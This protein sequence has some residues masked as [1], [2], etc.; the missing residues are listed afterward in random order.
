M[1]ARLKETYVKTVVPRLMKER[2]YSSVMAVRGSRR[3]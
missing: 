1:S 3:S 2:N